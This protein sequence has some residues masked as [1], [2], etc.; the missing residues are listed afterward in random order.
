MSGFYSLSTP[1]FS[2]VLPAVT[3]NEIYCRI[4]GKKTGNLSQGWPLP[5][6]TKYVR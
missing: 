3:L 6:D 5:T 2:T 4:G 1:I